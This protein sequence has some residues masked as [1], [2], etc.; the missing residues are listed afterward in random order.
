MIMVERGIGRDAE[1]KK[2]K[3]KRF[4]TFDHNEENLSNIRT[5][6]SSAVNTLS[7]TALV[8]SLYY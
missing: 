7:A 1:G 6:R 5:H 4:T 3:K 8:I 2:K